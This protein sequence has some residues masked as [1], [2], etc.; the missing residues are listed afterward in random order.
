MKVTCYLEQTNSWHELYITIVEKE[1]I[2]F[3]YDEFI[4]AVEYTD[5]SFLYIYKVGEILKGY[6]EFA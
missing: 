2:C 5:N 1:H 3:I 4:T 6:F